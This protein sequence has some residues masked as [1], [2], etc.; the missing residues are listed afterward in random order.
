M[1]V[2]LSLII[3]LFLP[4]I[5]H[6]QDIRL[7]VRGDDFGMTQGSLLAFEKAFIEGVLTC[8]SLLV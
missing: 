8:G 1:G 3:M 7:I 5:S 6:A 2:L 4:T